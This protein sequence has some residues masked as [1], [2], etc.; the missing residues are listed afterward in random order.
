[1]NCEIFTSLMGDYTDNYLN[2]EA[3]ASFDRHRNVCPDCTALFN[4]YNESSRIALSLRCGDMPRE[5]LSRIRNNLRT[6][7]EDFT[8]YQ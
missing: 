7:I 6:K 1:M 4:G 3:R 5:A 2:A 8:Q